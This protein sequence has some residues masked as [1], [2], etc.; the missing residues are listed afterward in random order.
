MP[1]F[2]EDKLK[3]EYGAKSDVPYKIMNS[4]GAIHGSKITAKGKE[5]EHK[6]EQ[7]I[8]G[9]STHEVVCVGEPSDV[10]EVDMSKYG[11]DYEPRTF[12]DSVVGMEPFSHEK[13]EIKYGRTFQPGQ[14]THEID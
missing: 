1:K 2:L 10:R 5:M 13:D 12:L 9:G 6:H 7:H 11:S 3:K 14:K 4:M 8:H